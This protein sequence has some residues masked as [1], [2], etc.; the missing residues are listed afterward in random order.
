MLAIDPTAAAAAGTGSS[1]MEGSGGAGNCGMVGTGLVGIAPNPMANNKINNNENSGGGMMNSTTTASGGSIFEELDIKTEVPPAVGASSI[2]PSKDSKSGIGG[3]LFTVEGLN[4]S[5]NDLEQL[6]ETSSNDECGS[7]QIHTPPDSN[8]PSNGCAVTTNTIDELKRSTNS[9]LV[10][11]VNVQGNSAAVMAALQN[12]NSV[13]NATTSGMASLNNSGGSLTGGGPGGLGVGPNTIQAEDLTK[14]FPTPPSHEQHHPNSSPCQMDIQM[15]DLNVMTSTN[16][17][18][19]QTLDTGL[20]I[21][22]MT[23]VK[24]EYSSE[25]GSPIEGPIEDWT[26][27]YRPPAQAIFVGSSKYA[28]LTNLPSQSM[29]PLSMPSNC[30]YKPSW[31]QPRSAHQQQQQQQQQQHMQQQQQQQLQ[32]QQQHQQLHELLSAA[33]R[34]PLQQQPRT[35]LGPMS[36]SPMHNTTVP[37]PLSSGGGG[38]SSLLL[39]QLNCPQAAL[40]NN[41]LTMQHIMQRPGMSPISPA[42]HVPFPHTSPMMQQHRQTPIH[43]P[44]PYE[45]AVASPALSTASSTPAYLNKQY[46]SQEPP[47]TP[48]SVPNHIQTIGG[49][50]SVQGNNRESSNMGF[51]A[52]ANNINS[53]IQELPEVSSVIVNILLYDT[54][55]NVFRD[56]NFDSSTVCVCNADNQRIGNIRG[57]D[58]GVYVPLP[59]TSFNPTAPSLSTANAMRA[60]SAFGGGGS[61]MGVALGSTVGGGS[62]LGSVSAAGIANSLD[63]PASLAGAGSSSSTTPSTATPANNAQQYITGY[64]DDDAVECTCGFSAVINRRLA[65]K[66]GLFYEDEMEIT[67][68]AEDPGRHK[69]HS[70][71]TLLINLSSKANNNSNNNNNTNSNGIVDKTAEQVAYS[72]FDLLLEQCSIIQTSSSAIHR[73]LQ[74]HRRRLSKRSQKPQ[75]V[76][77]IVNVLE[78]IDANDIIAL[79]LEQARLAYDSS[80]RMDIME[81]QMIPFSSHRKTSN[82]TQV[83]LAL[84][85]RINVHKWPYIPVGFSRSNKDIVSTMKSIQPMLQNAFHVKSRTAGSRDATYT[86]SGPLTWRQF[87]RL[88]GRA[89]GQCEPQPIPSVIVGHDKDWISVAPPAIHYWDKFLLEPYSYARDVVYL[90]MAPDNDYVLSKTKS[91]FKELSTIYE[92][93]KL[94]RHTP[95]CGWNGLLAVQQRPANDKAFSTNMDNWLKSLDDARLAE[96]LRLYAHAFQHQLAPYLNRVPGD[97]TLLNP[98]ETSARCSQGYSTATSSSTNSSSSSSS[99]FMM[100]GVNN[101]NTTGGMDNT[102]QGA[103]A[104]DHS[105]PMDTNEHSQ[106]ATGTNSSSDSQ[107]NSSGDAKP[108]DLK[109]D[110]KPPLVLGDPLGVADC[111]EEV[112]PSAIV[113]YVVE[114]FTFGSDSPELERLACIALLRMY[115]ELLKMIPDSV[116]AHINIQ[117]ISLE[118]ILELGRSR[119]RKRTS[120]EIKCL[121]LNIFSQCKR[122]MVHAQSVKSLTGFGTAANVEAFLKTKDEKN[123]RPYKMYT[124]PYILAP[125]HEKNEKT[126]FSRAAWGGM[127]GSPNEQ[128]YSVMYCNYCLSEDQSWLLATVTDDRGEMLEKVCINIDVPNRTK[129]RRAPA[130]RIGLNKLMDFILGLISQTTQTWR[131][132]VGRIGRIGHNELKSWSYLLGKQNLQKAT[133]QLRDMCKQCQLMYPPTILSACLVTLEPDAKLRV[134]PDQFTPDERFSI[135][136]PLSTPQDVTCTHILVFPTSAVCLVSV[137]YTYTCTNGM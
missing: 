20:G 29:A 44:P 123:R 35:P 49:P 27:V 18:G 109:P 11:A 90:V 127:R 97:K 83:A 36:S 39:N 31:Q 48:Q 80:N 59:G 51:Y 111:L 65:C 42:T 13:V 70:L 81:Q 62:I 7:V 92:M 56:H 82:N 132:V 88:A 53:I 104:A 126:D 57:S 63:S 125:M 76:A 45:V 131:L 2:S 21:S 33:P 47:Q 16:I 99:S 15:T 61:S 66:A 116:K 94:G 71:L 67:G 121:A 40:T 30:R 117:I 78:Y 103:G 5:P 8:N 64:V 69:K 41:P 34:T 26:Y 84:T 114:P 77:G 134:M 102:G 105:Q 43:P 32:Q 58:S 55:L 95:I 14:M 52:P 19:G 75:S 28:P 23:K 91:Y 119:S 101:S 17:M 38:S 137:E 6:F 1:G 54:A 24:Q 25:L 115:S 118:S 124:P 79:A 108:T 60:L 72:L 12:C 73:A 3:N 112:N 74:R 110:V 122:H 96:Q 113:L 46:H 68:I 120:D 4:P 135:Q 37:T 129:R 130:R 100:G 22:A 107:G 128:K 9:G 89:S 133:K 50:P 136:N 106:H 85:G 93:C 10:G 87:H 98:P 86:V